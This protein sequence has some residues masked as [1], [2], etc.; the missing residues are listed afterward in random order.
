MRDLSIDYLSQFF[1]QIAYFTVK[2]NGISL[3][4]DRIGGDDKR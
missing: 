3:Q 1:M 4:F 2:F